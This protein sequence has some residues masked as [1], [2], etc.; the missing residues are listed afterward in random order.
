MKFSADERQRDAGHED[1]IAFKKFARRSE[2][3]D[4]PLHAGHRR[5]FQSGSIGPGRQFVDVLLYG[6]VLDRCRCCAHRPGGLRDIIH[7]RIPLKNYVVASA[8][9]RQPPPP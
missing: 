4:T 6:F 1:N 5:R 3:P 8:L 9:I 2:R 7:R